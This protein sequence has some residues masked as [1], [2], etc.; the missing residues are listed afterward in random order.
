MRHRQVD[1][2][3]FASRVERMCEFIL[4]Q[5]E[6]KDGSLDIS[7]IQDLKKDAADIQFNPRLY[8]DISLR[9]LDKHIRGISHTA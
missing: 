2:K 4:D 9:G 5:I 8:G 3:D 6:E 1:V 7:F